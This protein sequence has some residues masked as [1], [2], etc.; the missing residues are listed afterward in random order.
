MLQSVIYRGIRLQKHYLKDLHFLS[1]TFADLP[2]IRGDGQKSKTPAKPPDF[3]PAQQKDSP[4]S[5]EQQSDGPSSP[6]V[7]SPEPVLPDIR[8]PEGFSMQGS[9]TVL[10][11]PDGVQPRIGTEFRPIYLFPHIVKMRLACKLKLYQTFVISTTLPLCITLMTK[12][13]MSPST[14]GIVIGFNLTAWTMLMLTGEIFRKFVGR[15][16]LRH[17]DAKVII[18]HLNFFGGRSDTSVFVKDIVPLS[19]SS[20]SMDE[21]VWKL[22][23]YDGRHFYMCTRAGGILCKD[24][25][26]A[27]FSSEVDKKGILDREDKA[28]E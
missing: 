7:R 3:S 6:A 23:L 22:N 25:W 19:E 13:M 8:D 11:A 2:N 17:D 27:V 12:D 20:E 15:I 18:S 21:L 16:Y 5:V 10:I 4:S 24:G 26:E 28:R 1:R 9:G 14:V